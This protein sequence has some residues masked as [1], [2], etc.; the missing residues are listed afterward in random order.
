MGVLSS[1]EFL[2]RADI[3]HFSLNTQEQDERARVTVRRQDVCSVL[4][5]HSVG[6]SRPRAGPLQGCSKGG[7]AGRSEK[8]LPEGQVENPESREHNVPRA[9]RSGW[10]SQW[11]AQTGCR[12]YIL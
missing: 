10:Q 5:K 1:S 7:Q 4:S 6:K 12:E 11:L 2:K 3:C 8:G 9:G